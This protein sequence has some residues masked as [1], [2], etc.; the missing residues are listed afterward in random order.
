M[1]AITSSAWERVPVGSL[2][3]F[4]NGVNFSKEDMGG[5]LGLINVKDIFSDSARIDF[6]SLDQ[7]DLAGRRGIENYYVRAGDLFFVRSSVKRDGIGLVSMSQKSSNK[8]VHC[9]FVIRF[10]PTSPNVESLFLTYLLRSPLYRQIVIGLSSGAAIINI[11]Q[12]SLGEMMVDLPPLSTQRKIAAIL[13]AYDDLIENNTRRIAILEEMAQLLY[14]E[15]FVHF[16]FPGHESVRMVEVYPK[17]S[18]GGLGPRVEAVPE[19]WALKQLGD[20]AQEVRRSAK[21]EEVD[22]QT[23]Y[24]GLAHMPKKSIALSDWG[25]VAETKST[26]LIF[27]RGEILFGKIRPYFHKVGVAPVDGVCSTDAV[28][29]VPKAPECFALTLACVSSEEF[30]EYATLTSQGTKMPRANWNVLV[31]YPVVLP[32]QPI[33]SRF[34]PIVEDIVDQIQ[35]LIFRNINLRRTRDL[36]LPRLVSGGVDVSRLGIDTEGVER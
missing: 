35:N 14:R 3:E 9:G 28:V 30:V 34:N 1:T 36:L 2:G 11:S 24:I 22:P 19:G 33:L 15:W 25:T 10:R 20:I 7:V 18:S 17:Q 27:R 6:E 13:S 12:S 29:I 23:P 31:E 32:P 16:R 26:K 8:V 5:G 21:P 4:R